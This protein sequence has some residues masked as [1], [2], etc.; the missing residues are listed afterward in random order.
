M[1]TIGVLIAQLDVPENRVLHL[2]DD[3]TAT[4]TGDDPH[5]CFLSFGG[6]KNDGGGESDFGSGAGSDRGEAD[7]DRRRARLDP[8]PPAE[9]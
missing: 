6:A 8:G 1:G 5:G 2:E 7:R 3:T 4:G 9:T